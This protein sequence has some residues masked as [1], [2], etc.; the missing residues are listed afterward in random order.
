MKRKGS[1]LVLI[2]PMLFSL[3]ACNS[4]LNEYRENAK[5]EIA[6]FLTDWQH[7]FNDHQEALNIAVQKGE[8][9]INKARNKK[10]I[11]SI[12]KN[13]KADIDA[14]L[15]NDDYEFSISTEMVV[16]KSGEDF[17]VE[18]K[19]KNNSGADIEMS[20]FWSPFWPFAPRWQYPLFIELSE[21]PE[22]V[23]FLN[24]ETYT[25]TW[26]LGA[27]FEVG[28]HDLRFKALFYPNYYEDD[29][30]C[31]VIWSPHIEIAVDYY[32]GK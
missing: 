31:V 9:A 12:V 24:N 26:T 3:T 4:G 25:E 28:K 11:D 15:I 5:A 10:E 14:L 7:I 17:S 19:L 30:N 23:T 32:L 6:R 20:Y 21:F 1:L 27:N 22:T 18:V 29:T 13:T 8:E 16:K 2:I